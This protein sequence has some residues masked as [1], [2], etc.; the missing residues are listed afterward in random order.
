MNK[1]MEQ[2]HDKKAERSHL[3]VIP[4]VITPILSTIC[5]FCKFGVNITKIMLLCGMEFILVAE[6]TLIAL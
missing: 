2:V 5:R 3:N 4:N 1:C 6:F